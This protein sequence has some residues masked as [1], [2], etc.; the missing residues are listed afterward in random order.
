LLEMVSM[1]YCWASIPLAAVKSARIMALS[2][3]LYCPFD[4][5]TF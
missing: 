4:F 1:L 5:A 2:R 3:L